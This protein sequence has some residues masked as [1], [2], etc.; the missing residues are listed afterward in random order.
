MQHLKA[1]MVGIMFALLAGTSQAALIG[2]LTFVDPTGT[3]GPN[4]SIDVWV[5]LTLDPTSDPLIFD[6]SASADDMSANPLPLPAEGFNF[7]DPFGFPYLFDEYNNLFQFFGRS[8]NDT[9][10]GP[11]QCSGGEYI[12]TGSNDPTS[13]L[14]LDTEPFTLLAGQSVD[15]L[16]YEITPNGDPAV[17]GTYELFDIEIGVDVTGSAD[18][19]MQGE[20]DICDEF[21]ENGLIELE[22]NYFTFATDCPDANCTFSRTVSVVPVPAAVWLMGS[23]LM[24]LVP[25]AR[26]NRR[27]HLS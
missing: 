13:W 27:R 8:C 6:T 17:P 3:V 14:N 16:L 15:M 22:A 1:S 10:A 5:R 2:Q 26:R 23:A 25:L 24:G 12:I 20:P 18:C 9:F 7:D 21:G 4:D 19:T 11:G